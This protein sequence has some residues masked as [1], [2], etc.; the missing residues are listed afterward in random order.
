MNNSFNLRFRGE[1]VPTL[2][3]FLR[4]TVLLLL[5]VCQ[6]LFGQTETI[7][8]T[9]NS[10]YLSG[11]HLK[12]YSNKWKVYAMDQDGSRQFQTVWTDYVHEFEL[13][14]KKVMSRTQELYSPEMHLQQ[15]WT[16]LFE[17]ETMLPIRASQ[18]RTNSSF[19]YQEFDG[20]TVT[21]HQRNPGSEKSETT[22]DYQLVPYDWTMYG[23]L[24]SGLPFKQ[25]WSGRIPTLNFQNASENSW[26]AVEIISHEKLTTEDGRTIK[27]TKVR[28]DRGLTFWLSKKAPYVIQ[29]ELLQPNNTRLQWIMY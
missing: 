11:S 6:S 21:V 25:G 13:N 29:L 3:R 28:T 16:N 1:R 14:G 4:I 10:K 18:F 9:A 5:V 20:S 27:T 15:V 24:L 19:L 8:V 22:F 23:V 2:F 12:P 26:L 7:T 17:K